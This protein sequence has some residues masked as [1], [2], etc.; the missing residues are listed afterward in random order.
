MDLNANLQAVSSEGV[1]SFTIFLK[2]TKCHT[3]ATTESLLFQC[4]Q[5]EELGRDC[6]G[7]YVW[8]REQF[9]VVPGPVVNSFQT[10]TG[11]VAFGDCYQDEWL[12]VK[13]LLEISKKFPDLIL[14]VVD[15]DGDFVLIEAADH[16]QNWMTPEN[17]MNCCFIKNGTF[18]L[19][20]DAQTAQKHQSKYHRLSEFNAQDEFENSEKEIVEHTTR[21]VLKLHSAV[22]KDRF[23]APK[24]LEHQIYLR[25]SIFQVRRF[26]MSHGEFAQCV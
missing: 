20:L 16:L 6:A 17:S 7:R 2:H 21:N 8:N 10:W 22:P 25:T 18:H 5:W 26:C 15:D 14:Q 19:T 4:L 24:A 3:A 23:R 9:H 12:V 11:R 1:V 13:I